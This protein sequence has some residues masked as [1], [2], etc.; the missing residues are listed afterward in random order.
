MAKK[1]VAEPEVMNLYLVKVQGQTVIK[2]AE[3][4]NPAAP[5]AICVESLSAGPNR[6]A[7]F[8]VPENE[9]E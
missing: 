1:K 4:T 3:S 6:I 8:F 5:G 7:V 9:I 2:I